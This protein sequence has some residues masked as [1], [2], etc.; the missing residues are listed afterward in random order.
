MAI[1]ASR[2]GSAGQGRSDPMATIGPRGDVAGQEPLASLPAGCVAVS[3]PITRIETARV[4]GPG[5]KGI[6][7]RLR[8]GEPA[9]GLFEV[10]LTAG[11]GRDLV[12]AVTD[13]EEAIAAWRGAGRSTNLPML[14]QTMEGELITPYPQIGAVA[15]GQHH[16]RRQ[17]SFL[18]GRRPRFLTR[19]KPGAVARS[20]MDGLML[21]AEDE[22]LA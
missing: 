6:G 17:H 4:I 14:L 20:A 9:A 21:A 7:L 12:V 1:N 18:R 15:L 22:G 8:P 13:E 5:W 11:D 2:I 3:G 10:F 16:Y 19:R